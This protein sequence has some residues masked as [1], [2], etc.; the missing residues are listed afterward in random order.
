MQI[1]FQVNL[2]LRRDMAFPPLANLQKNLTVVPLFW[3]Q[4]GY[5]TVPDSSLRLMDL[6]ILTPQIA[7]IGLILGLLLLGGAILSVA[8]IKY[9][10]RQRGITALQIYYMDGNS[11]ETNAYKLALNHRYEKCD[12][13]GEARRKSSG[14]NT[15]TTDSLLNESENSSKL[16]TSSSNSSS[17]LSSG[18][19]YP[20]SDTTISDILSS[21]T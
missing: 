9:F 14:V 21:P 3:A 1:R 8:V 2:M 7:T 20:I 16:I 19:L 5:N 15:A 11:N 4:E 6:A 17:S 10:K 18:K 12:L 13:Y